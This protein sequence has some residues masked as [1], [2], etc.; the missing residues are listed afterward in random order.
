M[1]FSDASIAPFTCETLGSISQNIRVKRVSQ[2]FKSWVVAEC[3]L[4]LHPS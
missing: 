3:L 4:E 2:H 1:G